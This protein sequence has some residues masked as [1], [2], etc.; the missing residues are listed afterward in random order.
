MFK[1][2]N[3]EKPGWA[4]RAC[5]SLDEAIN[6][7]HYRLG[8]PSTRGIYVCMSTQREAK[9]V[10]DRNGKIFHKAVR[11]T[12]N[13]VALKSLFIDFDF[14]GY[15]TPDA[16]IAAFSEFLKATDLPDPS[17]IV[18]T[19]G[20]QHI[21]WV[22]SRALTVEEWRPLAFA[23]AEATKRRG[24][25][26][27]TQCTTDAARILRIPDT[28][29]RKQETPRPVKVGMSSDHDYTPE[30][31]DRVLTPYKVALPQLNTTVL[32]R[33][34][35]IQGVN[36]ELS[37]GIDRNKLP[38]ANLDKLANECGFV[39][40]AIA[41][42]GAAYT[43]PE[44]NLTTLVSTFTEGGRADAHRMADKHPGYT[45]QST[46]ELFDRKE[47]DKAQKNL[48]WPSCAAISGSGAE[49]CQTCRHY[50]T[51]KSPFH[52]I[53]RP[54]A[55]QPIQISDPLNFHKL[56][57]SEVV[58]RINQEYLVLR[59]SGKIYRESESG[60]LS[61]IQ[62][63]DFVTA[64][65]GRM[66]EYTDA[67][68][69]TRVK[70]AAEAF[71]NAPTR[72]EYE[73]IGYWPDIKAAR[74]RHKNLFSGWGG[75]PAKGDCSIVLD[76]I[77]DVVA[78][79]DVAKAHY[80]LDWSADIL[81]NPGRKPGV[82]LVLRGRQGTGKTVILDI[83]RRIIGPANVLVTP[84]KDRI[85]GRFNSAIMNKILLVGE[86][87]LFAGD[88]ATMDKLKHLITG[89]TIP[90]EFK[91]GDTLEVPS[92]HRLILTSNH[93]QVINAASEERRFV[94]YD[95]ANNK[96]GDLKYFERLYAVAEG[97]DSGTGS[98]FMQFLL[99]RDLTHFQP[100]EAQSLFASDRALQAQ[101][102]LSLPPPLMWLK[103]VVDTVQQ[104]VQGKYN[105][106]DG[107]PYPDVPSSAQREYLWPPAFARREAVEAF[108][109]WG[110]KAKPY[111][112]SEFTGSEE[113]FWSEVHKVIPIE[114]TN[115]KK[116]GARQVQIDLA[117]V[118]RNFDKYL[119][120][121][122]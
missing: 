122:A 112:L 91:F 63:S 14:K 35:P 114:K 9:E 107:M 54:T 7:I 121:D 37:A 25:K 77:Q 76:H 41:T 100:W 66:A 47:R 105:W 79:G 95:V 78:D 82:A 40:R 5:K 83:L 92:F 102:L 10:P 31:M 56:P 62:K 119:R 19:G 81:Q 103:E 67:N 11:S 51:G 86:E 53:P 93:E 96:R 18:E 22:L 6:V 28:F 70:P 118:R 42:G 120:G 74:A 85:L 44:W 52:A 46:D 117:D 13:A 30:Q 27:D 43:N 38:P 106:Y 45:Q 69:N 72:R 99:D 50:L 98:A 20:G 34:A 61:A 8:R 55:S 87:M 32:P 29:N 58:R 89:Q 39:R 24:L 33:L 80:F 23:L 113:R 110:S 59:T 12:T 2:D 111:G 4:G 49:A 71:L 15:D 48:G 88:R 1:P 21:Y 75:T 104:G 57:L 101:K 68:G 64:M 36:S 16:A 97:R 3:Q 109:A 90:I 26:C 17:I 116:R 65:G 60:E 84:D 108:R 73:G 94:T 115:H